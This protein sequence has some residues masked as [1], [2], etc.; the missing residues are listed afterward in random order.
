MKIGFF[1]IKEKEAKFLRPQLLDHESDFHLSFIDKDHLP[2]KRNYEIISV[3][4]GSIIDKTVMESFPNLKL[5]DTRTTG[6]DHI[7]LKTA[8]EKNILVS[9][10]PF[11]GANT[12]AEFAFGL[13]LTLSRKIFLAY[14]RIKETGSFDLEGLQGFD[15][16]GKTIGI[17]GTG[18]IGRHMIKIAKGFEMNVVA[19]D[20]RPDEKLA[21]EFG[22]RYLDFEELLKNSDV[23]SIHIPYLPST[24]YL[25]NRK[26]IYLIK[27]GC[28][29][30]NTSRGAIVETEAIVR[31]LHEG[32]L[33]GA[34]L[35]VL[36]EEG[37]VKNVRQ[38]LLYGRPEEHNLKTILQNNILVDMDNAIIT[39]HMA[40]NSKEALHRI[41]NTTV[42]NI[43]SLVEGKP[44]NLV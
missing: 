39:P 35:D 31:A 19:Y 11:Y 26:N 18:R 2:E 12:V 43:K 34:G 37:P 7:D 29:L 22:F 15:L 41:L 21:Q 30:I 33:A 9:N 42:Q 4:T 10:V 36:E 25:I 38:F 1:E 13:L 3:F 28:I 17:V 40:F 8:K 23:I 44:Q 6:Y 20:T 27:K 5:I 24:H 32:I 16:M 14:D